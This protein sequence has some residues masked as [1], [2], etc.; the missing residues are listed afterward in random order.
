MIAPSCPPQVRSSRGACCDSWINDAIAT[1]TFSEDAFRADI[2]DAYV[3]HRQALEKPR[4]SASLDMGSSVRVALQALSALP[5]DAS[6][7]V[8]G[9]AWRSISALRG[10]I[11]E[12][13]ISRRNMFVAIMANDAVLWARVESLAAIYSQASL[14]ESTQGTSL[15]QVGSIL[16]TMVRNGE[17]ARTVDGSIFHPTARGRVV[18]LTLSYGTRQPQTAFE[19]QRIVYSSMLV[20][21]AELVGVTDAPIVRLRC[22]LV[23][24]VVSVV[25]YDGLY[26]ADVWHAWQR[27]HTRCLSP[28]ASRMQPT[29]HLLLPFVLMVCAQRG[30]SLYPVGLLAKLAEA[31]GDVEEFARASE[32]RA[33]FGTASKFYEA[34][35]GRSHD[36]TAPAGAHVMVQVLAVLSNLIGQAAVLKGALIVTEHISGK[37]CDNHGRCLQLPMITSHGHIGEM[38]DKRRDMLA[39][40]GSHCDM[41]LPFRT[42]AP[43]SLR[44]IELFQRQPAGTMASTNGLRNVAL[45]RVITFGSPFLLSGNQSFCATF[46]DWLDGV[47]R[48]RGGFGP[49][50]T[51]AGYFVCDRIYGRN[52]GRSLDIAESVWN[53]CEWPADVGASRVFMDFWKALHSGIGP[54][55]R[56]KIPHVG[57]S[58]ALLIAGECYPHIVLEQ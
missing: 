23:W 52:T 31:S 47:E 13:G 16:W 14:P 6:I 43:S 24:A 57:M 56:Y 7:D 44:L 32:P 11:S 35:V 19:R 22:W 54:S 58:L 27:P 29:L 36:I 3:Q 34:P 50:L 33:F 55:R 12:R 37:P 25:G 18:T 49:G 48:A 8:L 41:F 21:I 4:V 15:A 40:A 9:D 30:P 39:K 46:D 5:G 20:I 53:A 45:A 28:R 38:A 51:D 17:C 2:Q 1:A 10:R 26:H 42:F